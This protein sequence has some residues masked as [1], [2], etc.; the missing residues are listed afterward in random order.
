MAGQFAGMPVAGAPQFRGAPPLGVLPGQMGIQ[1]P[2]GPRFGMGPGGPLPQGIPFGAQMANAAAQQ[3]ARSVM[4]A[5][6]QAQALAQAQRAFT[7]TNQPLQQGANVRFAN[8]RAQPKRTGAQMPPH[9]QANMAGQL[10]AGATAMMLGGQAHTGAGAAMMRMP[11]ALMR[12]PPGASMQQVGMIPRGFRMPA[13]AAM[14]QYGMMAPGAASAGQPAAGQPSA[15]QMAVQ[16][17]EPPVAA[18]PLTAAMLAQAAQADPG[19]AKHILGERLYPIISAWH[20]Q[21]AGM[22]IQLIIL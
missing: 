8:A 17:A 20:P 10:N 3:Q 19:A 12:M 18:E 9:M 13:T 6:T 15:R 14:M 11:G 7:G 5:N 16:Q 2:F 1:G 21:L 22:Y 4:A